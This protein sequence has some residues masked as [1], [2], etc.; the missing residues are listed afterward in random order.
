M[1]IIIIGKWPEPWEIPWNTRRYS[2]LVVLVEL[3]VP[4]LKRA[5]RGERK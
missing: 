3:V 1:I 2:D 4:F 5:L